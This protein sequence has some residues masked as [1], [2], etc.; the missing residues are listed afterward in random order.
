VSND[1]YK[2]PSWEQHPEV[3]RPKLSGP[4]TPDDP[5]GNETRSMY[6]MSGFFTYWLI[7]IATVIGCFLAPDAAGAIGL[8]GLLV[9][10]TAPIV[11][12]RRLGSTQF[13]RGMV[14]GFLVMLG[15]GILGAG[16]CFGIVMSSFH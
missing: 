2:P 15:L 8:V 4:D 1:P 5:A 14:T 10:F 13:L 16:V 9:I 7:V 12:C 6:A 11:V 3:P